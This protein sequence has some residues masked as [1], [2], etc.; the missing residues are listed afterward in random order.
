VTELLFEDGRVTGVRATHAGST[1]DLRANVTVGADGRHST[2]AK[3]VDAEE[4]LAYDSPR[5]MFW[6][7][8][9]PPAV[10]RSSAYPFDMMLKFDG[11]HRRVIFPTDDGQLLIGTMPPVNIARGWRSD[12][13]ASYFADARLDPEIE[14]LVTGG[15]MNGRI[16]GTV[17]ERYFFRRAAG[18]GWALAGDAGHHKDPIIGWGIAEAL[19]QAKHLAAAIRAGGDAA[20]ERYWRQRDVDSIARF[21]LAEER[22]ALEAINPVLP[23]V[24]RKLPGRPDL[25]Q[26]LASEIEYG[27]NPYEL[28]PIPKVAGW[29]LAAALRRPRLLFDFVAQGKR[30]AAVKS[31]IKQRQKLLE[32]V[33]WP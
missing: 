29:T 1:I 6:A 10:W 8:W 31:E 32:A 2:V 22:G 24:L 19:E 9:Q 20:L 21:R 4:Y 27:V 14:P 5:G 16:I 11:L 18:P 30:A 12:L 17:S 3:A 26:R 33:A 25:A 13:E 7:Y 23:V 28:L 15:S